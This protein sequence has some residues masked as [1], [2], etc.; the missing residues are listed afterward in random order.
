VLGGATTW[1]LLVFC[2]CQKTK[3]TVQTAP[4]FLH[5]LAKSV[6]VDGARV[7]ADMVAAA[8]VVVGLCE[9][10]EGVARGREVVRWHVVEFFIV[11]VIF[12][13]VFLV[14][15][16]N[17]KRERTTTERETRH[18]FRARQQHAHA[19]V[20]FV[21]R[22]QRRQARRRRLRTWFSFLGMW[23]KRKTKTKKKYSSSSA[24]R[25][26]NLASVASCHPTPSRRRGRCRP[27]GRDCAPRDAAQAGARGRRRVVRMFFLGE[28][29]KLIPFCMGKTYSG[30]E[31]RLL[32]G[33]RTG[34]VA[35]FCV[36]FGMVLRH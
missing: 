23:G 18:R 34:N 22:S 33:A 6:L 3:K 36:I 26:T 30:W 32:C 29:S 24:S 35:W 1:L 31:L 13:L 14:L 10:G 12:F 25:T 21:T 2:F 4:S 27:E 11:V 20:V 19:P 16:K 7:G 5:H 17:G 15:G 9:R 8:A 28:S